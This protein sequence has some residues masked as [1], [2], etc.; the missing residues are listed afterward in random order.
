VGREVSLELSEIA[1]DHRQKHRPHDRR[2][3]PP[4]LAE[5]RPCLG[6]NGHLDLRC[7]LSREISNAPFVVAV[8]VRVE[9][10]DGDRLNARLLR[11]GDRVSSLT[12]VQRSDHFAT[13]RYPLIDR[14]AQSAGNQRPLFSLVR[15]V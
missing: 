8:D 9:K 15:V 5:L 13:G 3:K 4:E 6:G 11:P 12:L 2:R 10:A 14:E 1:A 7:D